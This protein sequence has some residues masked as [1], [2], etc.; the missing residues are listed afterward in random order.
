AGAH[1]GYAP[2]RIKDAITN[3]GTALK[4]DAELS[5]NY[6]AG[7][8]ASIASPV[9]IEFTGFLMDFSNQV[10]PVSASSGGSGTGLVNGGETMHIGAEA[11]IRFD[12]HKLL[13]TSYIISLSAY[14]TYVNSTYSND[15]FITIGNE[16]V[17]V[18]DNKL[19][20]AP[21]FTFTGSLDFNTTF[22]LGF[23]LSSTYVSEQ[24]TD[25]LN[26]NEAVPSGETG[27]M[28]SFITIDITANYLLT[29]LNSSVYFSVKNLMD[30][31]YIA[32]RRPEFPGSFRLA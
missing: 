12:F 25:E 27:L 21:E 17:N 18:K 26:T 13:R 9:Y 5:W 22:G 14:S 16:K 11:G 6:E 8:R 30:E 15:R 7:I 31:R 24:F 29:D 19:P 2:P 1:R 4:L 28:P 10:I 20:Y 23:N 3:D 32:S